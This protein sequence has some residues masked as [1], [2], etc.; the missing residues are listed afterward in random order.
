MLFL[1]DAFGEFG[2]DENI[3]QKNPQWSKIPPSSEERLQEV[4]IP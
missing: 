4:E 1:A 3:T 2:R